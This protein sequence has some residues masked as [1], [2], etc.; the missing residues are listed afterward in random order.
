MEYQY[1]LNQW[2]LGPSYPAWTETLLD[3]NEVSIR[4]VT[5]ADARSEAAFIEALSPEARR[6]RFLGQMRQPSEELIDR[7]TNIDYEH[8]FAFVAEQPRRQLQ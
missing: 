8:D 1:S 7:L 5:K 4:P 2:Q 6:F 3:G